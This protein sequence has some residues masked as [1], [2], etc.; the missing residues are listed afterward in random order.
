MQRIYGNKALL[1]RLETMAVRGHAAHAVLFYGEKGSGR[2]TLA[3]YYCR[4]LLCENLTDGK[5]CGKCK[6]CSNITS[7]VHPDII[8]AEKSGKLGG[9]SVDTAR[10]ICSDAFAKPNNGDVKIYIFADCRNMDARTQNTLLKIIE[11]P[12]PHACFIFTAETKDEFLP[13]VISRCLSFG[14]SPCTADECRAALA[15]K[16]YSREQTAPAVGCFGGNIGMCIEYIENDSVKKIPRLTKTV[17][18]S[19]INR[20]EY[21]LAAALH[22]ISKER[23]DI[24]EVLVLMGRTLRDAAMRIS[25]TKSARIGCDERCADALAQSLTFT[26][27]E[28]INAVSERAWAAIETNANAA[29]VMTSLCA[30]ISE[31]LA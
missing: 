19:I 18:E 12:P 10:K 5:P 9:Y 4:L 31:I 26:Q 30:E 13:T 22:S 11:E 28:R 3:E 1:D 14:I 8:F 6:P 20:D 27:A 29:L 25:D 24:R 15:E 16:G 23:A 21:T 7:A 2:K 17:L